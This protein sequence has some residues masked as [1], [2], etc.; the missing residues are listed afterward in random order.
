MSN[1]G[2]QS[3]YHFIPRTYKLELATFILQD[4]LYKLSIYLF[5]QFFISNC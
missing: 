5:Y 4:L 3:Y 2:V 1:M